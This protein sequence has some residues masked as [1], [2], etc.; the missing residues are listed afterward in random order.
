MVP[1]VEIPEIVRHYTPYFTSVFSPAALIQFQRYVSGVMVSENKTVD[2][3]QSALCVR[4]AQ[5]E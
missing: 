4:G 1:F 2:F 3:D 5:P